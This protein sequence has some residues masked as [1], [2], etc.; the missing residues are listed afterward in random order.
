MISNVLVGASIFAF[1][2]LIGVIIGY[3]RHTVY[4]IEM[5]E[6]DKLDEW[7]GKYYAG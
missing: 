6:N 7:Y 4:I 5:Y 3:V 1:G 2:V